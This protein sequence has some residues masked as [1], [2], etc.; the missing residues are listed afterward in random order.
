MTRLP[1]VPD[2][3]DDVKAGMAHFVGTGP[4]GETCG[5]C[6]FR[7]YWRNAK[8][9]YNPKTKQLDEKRFKSQGCKMYLKLAMRYGPPVNKNWAACKY[10]EKQT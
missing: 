2:A 10:W 4:I 9:K 6:R 3:I 8:T 7:G 5:S 1:G